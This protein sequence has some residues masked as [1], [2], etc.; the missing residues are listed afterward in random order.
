MNSA[1]FLTSLTSLLVFKRNASSF[2]LFERQRSQM[3]LIPYELLLFGLVL[4]STFD[5]KNGLQSYKRLYMCCQYITNIDLF[6]PNIQNMTIHT[7]QDYERFGYVSQSSHISNSHQNIFMWRS[8]IYIYI[9]KSY[10]YKMRRGAF[11]LIDL[12]VNSRYNRISVVSKKTTEVIK[13]YT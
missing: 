9:I 12:F 11:V 7:L 4:I 13:S 1:F 3:P 5:N 10:L 8:Y 2:C 6:T